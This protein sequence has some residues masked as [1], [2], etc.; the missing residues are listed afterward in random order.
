MDYPGYP[1]E[2]APGEIDRQYANIRKIQFEVALRCGGARQ[3]W[4]ARQMDSSLPEDAQW[5]GWG[6]VVNHECL[7][8][9]HGEAMHDSDDQTFID[10]LA[11][12]ALGYPPYGRQHLEALIVERQQ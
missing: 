12:E 7:F 3:E 4:I 5:V 2:L 6:F 8:V 9:P 1:E 10:K 11:E